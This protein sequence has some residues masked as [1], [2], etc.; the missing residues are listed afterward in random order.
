MASNIR[1]PGAPFASAEL[2]SYARSNR[3]RIF[4]ASTRISSG[5]V[6]EPLARIPSAHVPCKP[7]STSAPTTT[8]ESTTALTPGQRRGS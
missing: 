7:E 1:S 4:V 5:A 6:R 2:S 8:D 3:R